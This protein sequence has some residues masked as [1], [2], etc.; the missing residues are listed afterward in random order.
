MSGN[1]Y[2]EV[3]YKAVSGHAL[4]PAAVVAGSV[5]CRERLIRAIAEDLLLPFVEVSRIVGGGG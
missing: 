5:V 3:I 2:T 4:Y 1:R